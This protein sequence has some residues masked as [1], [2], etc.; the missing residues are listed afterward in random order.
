MALIH[1]RLY[2]AKDFAIIDFNSYIESLAEHLFQSYVTD[3]ERISLVIDA[4][5]VQLE[6]DDAI[7]CGLIIN[8]LVSN[9][10]KYAFPND[11]KG[12]IKVCFHTEADGCIMLTVTD[13]GI[14]LPAD[15]NFR[16]TES[17]GL[18]LVTM[19]ARQLRGDVMTES[20]GGTSF[21]IRFKGRI[22]D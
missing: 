9:S 3:P 11:R 7:P 5:A 13:N 6:I 17:L 8:E 1:E 20:N 15:L 18:Q 16:N 19:L 10:L 12:E 14:G 4:G 2:Q 21:I 22:M